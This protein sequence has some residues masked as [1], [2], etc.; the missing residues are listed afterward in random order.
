MEKKKR[1]LKGELLMITGYENVPQTIA[2]FL[3][4]MDRIDEVKKYLNGWVSSE[5][6]RRWKVTIRFKLFNKHLNG[7]IE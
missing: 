5:I 2:Y 1:I 7:N 6:H 3:E 4:E